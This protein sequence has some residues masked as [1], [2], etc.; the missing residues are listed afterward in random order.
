VLGA[1][2][3]VV[4]LAR[5]GHGEL[6]HLLGARGIGQFAE[7]DRGLP[8]PDRLFHPLVNLIEVDVQVGEYRGCDSL[9]LADEPEEDVLGPDVVVL[10]AD[11]LLARHRQ[12]LT[13]TVGEVVVHLVFG[14]PETRLRL[15][16]EIG[17]GR[18]VT[19]RR[20]L[21]LVGED[22]PNVTRS[23]CVALGL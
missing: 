12:D 4:E 2:V 18:L 20:H 16:G 9:P 7:R 14:V 10:E 23:V 8:L 5:L 1:D 13:N 11:R 6:E 22:L 3:R 17:V 21:T 15:P 19:I